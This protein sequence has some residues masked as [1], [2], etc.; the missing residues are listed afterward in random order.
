MLALEA[1][2]E[3]KALGVSQNDAALYALL[4]LIA[5]V[6]DTNMIHRGGSQEAARRRTEAR[7]LFPVLT[8][9][10]IV[11]RLRHLDKSYIAANLSPGGCADL[12]SLAMALDF[13]WEQ[14]MIT[15]D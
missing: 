12:L 11:P 3:W 14:E 4:R 2:R 1:L 5:H 7:D 6:E 15:M 8:P 9:E 13:L 10:T